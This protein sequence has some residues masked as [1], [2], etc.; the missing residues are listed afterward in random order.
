MKVIAE[1]VRPEDMC[2]IIDEI[3]RK[4]ADGF[5]IA[6]E[7]MFENDE[8]EIIFDIIMRLIG[9]GDLMEAVDVLTL[10]FSLVD[11]KE[12][13]ALASLIANTGRDDV[14][15]QFLQSFAEYSGRCVIRHFDVEVV[16]ELN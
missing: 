11:A 4:V 3:A 5:E 13:Y 9:N 7:C 6:S 2:P 14:Y 10:S 16:G 8:D 1:G 15:R 12:T